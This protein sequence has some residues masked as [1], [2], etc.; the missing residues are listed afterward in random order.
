MYSKNNSR[1]WWFRLLYFSLRLDCRLHPETLRE[2]D[3]DKI[4]GYLD[5]M[6]R[7]MIGYSERLTIINSN[8]KGFS[9]ISKNFA[10]NLDKKSRED[11]K[12]ALDALELGLTTA[13]FML[14]CR[15]AEKMASSYYE[16]FTQNSS[17]GKKW[18]DML[19]EIKNKHEMEHNVRRP[20]LALFDFLREKRNI[21]QHPG[22]RFDDKECQKILNYLEDFQKEIS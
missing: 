17:K 16:I 15:V 2:K 22:E 14:F 10:K 5:R 13:S 9:T 1:Y 7:I 20:V 4:L 21:A 8:I 11:F 19:I 6:I 3:F 12:E 18:N